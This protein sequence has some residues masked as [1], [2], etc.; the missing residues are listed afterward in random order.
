[1][2]KIKRYG[3]WAI[4]LYALKTAF[5]VLGYWLFSQAPWFEPYHLLALP[6]GAGALFLAGYCWKYGVPSFGHRGKA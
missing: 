4:G 3:P 5:Y 6:V 1:M 2:Q